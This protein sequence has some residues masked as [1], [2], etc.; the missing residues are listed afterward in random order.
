MQECYKIRIFDMIAD[1][2]CKRPMA[3]WN[4]LVECNDFFV[5]LWNLLF[6]AIDA[7]ELCIKKHLNERTILVHQSISAKI[8]IMV[9]ASDTA[10]GAVVQQEDEEK[11]DYQMPKKD[12]VLIW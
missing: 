4:N 1:R 7:F 3:G 5:I 11:L 12:I 2:Y 6:Y 9:D 10:M 8:A